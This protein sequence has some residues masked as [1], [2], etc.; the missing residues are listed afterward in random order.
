[1]SLKLKINKKNITGNIL[2]V[3]TALFLVLNCQSIW[4]NTLD[5]NY[6]IYE[7]CLL[8]IILNTLYTYFHW[9]K[10]GE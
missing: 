8:F 3:V 4:Q 6:H 10:R 5:K 7:F 2:D 9:K 1:M